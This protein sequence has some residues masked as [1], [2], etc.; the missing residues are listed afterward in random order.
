[1]P[2]TDF[3]SR[4]FSIFEVWDLHIAYTNLNR[5]CD[6]LIF[7]FDL[8]H[9]ILVGHTNISFYERLNFNPF[10]RTFVHFTIA[11]LTWYDFIP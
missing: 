9:H 1:M 5:L 8:L 10:M 2:L 6:W 7:K 3:S 4:V 11:V